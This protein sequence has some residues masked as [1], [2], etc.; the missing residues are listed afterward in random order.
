[1]KNLGHRISDQT[2]GNILKRN[3]IAPSD[4]RKKNT[5]W[6][7]FIR[8]HKDV[9][10]ATDFFTAEVWTSLGLTTFYVLL[11]IQLSTRRVILGGITV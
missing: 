9:L 5:T 7:S 8:Q 10:W 4:D 6:A 3:G 1:M 11:F 2:V